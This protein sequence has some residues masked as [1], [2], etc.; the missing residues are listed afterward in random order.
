MNMNAVRMSHYQPDQR[1]LELCDSL[2]LFV[3]DELSDLQDAYDT[4]VGPKRIKEL[5][6]K[7]VN[8]PSVVIWD[9]GNEGGW[10]FKNEKWFH[11]YD[12]Q[13]R[14]VIYPWLHRNGIDCMHYI[15]YDFGINRFTYGTDVFMPTEFLHGLY[16]GGL[17]ASLNDF[18]KHFRE[19]PR[20]AGGFLWV[21]ADEAVLRTDFDTTFYDSD[22]NHAPDG[23]LG[24]HHEKEG[25]FYAIKDIWSP[26]QLKP[27]VLSKSWNGNVLLTNDFLFSNLDECYFEW[28][29]ITT[30]TDGEQVTVGKNRVKGP[31]ASPGETIKMDLKVENLSQSEIFKLSAFKSNGQEIRSW[32]WPLKK[33]EY[34]VNSNLKRESKPQAQMTVE[35]VQD[36]LIINADGIRYDFNLQDGNLQGIL[37]DGKPLSLSGG[38]KVL[39]VESEIKNVSY[40][41]DD[42]G[43]NLVV[44]YNSYPHRLEW[45]ILNNGLLKLQANPIQTAVRNMDFIGIGFNYPEHFC[46]GLKWLGDGP[47][48]VWK[49][50]KEGVHYGIWEKQYNNTITGESFNDLIYPEF[51]GYHANV[52]WCELQTTEGNFRVYSEYPNLYMHLFTPQT[53]KNVTGGTMPIFPETDLSFLYDIPAIGTKFKSSQDLGGP[54]TEKGVDGYH[55][56]QRNDPICLWFDFRSKQN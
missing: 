35:E 31:K 56:G 41:K 1:F 43:V 46:V 52:V 4:V 28:E 20:F 22:R 39:G 53:P 19:N 51:K 30:T 23:I 33:T 18:W 40:Q 9:H 13:K 10:D 54:A 24:P 29:L 37:V 26:V 27:M 38:A 50:R 15:S 7:D 8:H 32:S 11:E 21:F 44:E 14:P 12:I 16:D 36:T 25:S 42:S 48:R 49:N 47:Y 3:L 5:V 45:T 6:L 55:G 17:G 2:G 34:Y